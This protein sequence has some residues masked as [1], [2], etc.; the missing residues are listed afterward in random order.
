MSTSLHIGSTSL[1]TLQNDSDQKLTSRSIETAYTIMEDT[2]EN[3]SLLRKLA[4]P[5]LYCEGSLIIPGEQARKIARFSN[6]PLYPLFSK[7]ELVINDPVHRQLLSTLVQSILPKARKSGEYCSFITPGT[8]AASPLSKLVSQLITLQGFTP[9]ATSISLAAGL[10]A[11]P[12]TSRLSGYAVYLGH[13]HSE[14]GLIHQ[15]RVVIQ[16]STPYGSEW[17]DEQLASSF[18]LFTTN[19][20]GQQVPDTEKARSKRLSPEINISPYLTNHSTIT[21]W[22]ESLFD[23]LLDNFVLQMQAMQNYLET[24]DSLPIVYLGEL[25]HI[26]GFEE[27]LTHNLSNRQVGFDAQQVTRI[28]DENFSI[29]RGALVVSAMEQGTIRPAA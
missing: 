20:E 12:A 18:K 22:Y 24:L 1:R 23:S 9:L 6:L 11:F 3:C 17:M 21:S 15:S 16:H 25:S 10:S 27:F 2:N 8:N 5:F 29:A 13:S 4:T 26:G 14:I 7:G 28:Q 19:S